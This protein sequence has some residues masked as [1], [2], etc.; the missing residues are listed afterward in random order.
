[1]TVFNLKPS[2]K[3]ILRILEIVD[4][5][6]PCPPERPIIFVFLSLLKIF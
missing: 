4:F 6:E 2:F 5:P 1:M 3:I